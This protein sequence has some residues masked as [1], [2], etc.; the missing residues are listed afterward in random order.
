MASTDVWPVCSRIYPYFNITSA[1]T[2][3]NTGL[4]ARMNTPRHP[5]PGGEV[6]PGLVV[7]E[8]TVF[9]VHWIEG[10]HVRTTVISR[11]V[12]GCEVSDALSPLDMRIAVPP[13]FVTN[14]GK[15]WVKEVDV[16]ATFTP[17]QLFP[18]GPGLQSTVAS[19][20]AELG[21]LWDSARGLYVNEVEGVVN[22]RPTDL[23]V[24]NS[25]PIW[26]L[27]VTVR[28]ERPWHGSVEVYL[29]STTVTEHP[30]GDDMTALSLC[31]LD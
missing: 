7:Q 23:R 8:T 24:E 17:L 21:L 3:G 14:D 6:M 12:V 13:S 30:A 28:F 22:F 29:L 20:C 9:N 27:L 2:L 16:R 11:E 26:D 4:V 25:E 5:G 1:G 18:S 31:I 19:L 10:G 15:A